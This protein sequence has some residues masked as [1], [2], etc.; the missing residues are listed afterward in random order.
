[1]PT[2]QKL[3]IV[4][5]QIICLEAEIF[6]FLTLLD[7]HIPNQ[8]Q[9]S[10]HSHLNS[11]NI[12]LNIKSQS[13]HYPTELLQWQ[14]MKHFMLER[15]MEYNKALESLM[16]KLKHVALKGEVKKRHEIALFFATDHRMIFPTSD[17]HFTSLHLHYIA[18]AGWSK[19][20]F[21]S[22]T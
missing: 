11:G 6:Y 20:D 18:T 13:L 14:C 21:E 2:R 15:K 1:M 8:Q 17:S 16:L 10:I 19:W 7:R 9:T 4:V 12:P 22:V 5:T 3:W